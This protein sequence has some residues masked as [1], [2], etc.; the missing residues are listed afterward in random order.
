MKGHQVLVLIHHTLYT[1]THN[2]SSLPLHELQ[3]SAG[4]AVFVLHCCWV[5]ADSGSIRMREQEDLT[6]TQVIQRKM[7]PV[8]CIMLTIKLNMFYKLQRTSP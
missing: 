3:C 1:H 4:D 7:P 8:T 2:L 5:Q 6:Q